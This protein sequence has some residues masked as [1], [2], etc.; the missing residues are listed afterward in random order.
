LELRIVPRG[1]PSSRQ[2]ALVASWNGVV[3]HRRDMQ[4]I[5]GNTNSELKTV[6]F[7]LGDKGDEVDV[8][9]D[10]WRLERRKER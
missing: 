4:S 8:A 5:S 7:A 1:E 10:D 3:V 6:I 2:F 9:F